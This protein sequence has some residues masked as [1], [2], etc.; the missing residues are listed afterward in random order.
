VATQWRN[1]SKL[2]TIKLFKDSEYIRLFGD[3]DVSEEFMENVYKKE[4]GS[5]FVKVESGVVVGSSEEER[6]APM[7]PKSP[8]K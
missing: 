2:D 5:S 7:P 1:M 3:D 8:Y 6:P 4:L